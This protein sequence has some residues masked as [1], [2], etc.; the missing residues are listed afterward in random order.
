[1]SPLSPFSASSRPNNRRYHRRGPGSLASAAEKSG[2]RPRVPSNRA[3]SGLRQVPVHGDPDASFK[4][5]AG[6]CGR[7]S[8]CRKTGTPA[9]ARIG[10]QAKE[11]AGTAHQG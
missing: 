1:M 4:S 2:V 9:K 5:R 3:S 11:L 7:K 8:Q 10:K 6:T